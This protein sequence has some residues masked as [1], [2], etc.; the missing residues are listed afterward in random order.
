VVVNASTRKENKEQE[1]EEHMN[2]DEKKELLKHRRS[3]RRLQKWMAKKL[4]ESSEC[5]EKPIGQARAQQHLAFWEMYKFL[6][7]NDILIMKVC[8]VCGVEFDAC[9][10]EYPGAAGGFV[11]DCCYVRA[12]DDQEA[13]RKAFK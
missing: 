13:K 3:L 6:R 9:R 8:A 7:D 10:T 1:G 5:L 11:C 12:C 2:D 4:K